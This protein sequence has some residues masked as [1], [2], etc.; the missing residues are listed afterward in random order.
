MFLGFAN[1]YRQF[2]KDLNKITVSLTLICKITISLALARPSYTRKNE[3]KTDID[4]SSGLSGSRNNDRII[5]LLSTIK[6]KKNF[7][8]GF[9]T[10]KTSLAF[11][12]LRKIFTKVPILYYFNLER[13]I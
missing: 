3:N 8:I 2:I 4:G 13:H 12:Q 5:N 1:F 6:V 7:K 10:Y 11:T 9:I